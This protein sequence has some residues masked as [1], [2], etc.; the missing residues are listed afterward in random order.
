MTVLASNRTLIA[1]S[2]NGL[3]NRLKVLLSARALAEASGRAMQMRWAVSR[4]CSCD[5]ERLFQNQWNVSSALHLNETRVIDLT[6]MP[7]RAFPDLLMIADAEITVRHYGWLI[8]PT[9]YPHHAPLQKRCAELMDELEPIPN[10]QARVQSLREQFFRDVM[11]GVHLR[12][13]DFVRVRPDT[14]ANLA[15]ATQVVD[16]WLTRQ[17]DA[18]ILVCTDDGAMDPY[19]RQ[20]IRQEGIVENFMK[21]YGERV[22]WTQPRS[23]DRGTPEAIEDA[24]VDLLLL[25]QTNFFVGTRT[26]SFSELAVFGRA[27]PSRFTAAPT[28]AYRRMERVMKW[29]GV[30]YLLTVMNQKEFGEQQSFMTLWY[31]YKSRLGALFPR[32]K[33]KR[34]PLERRAETEP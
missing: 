20:E 14:V 2:H 12:R 5:F 10:I 32:T 1:H 18:G 22:V 13:G 19:A 7:W 27:I 26:S 28:D 9:R 21:R 8:D 15:Q 16:E 23:L 25:R 3:C 24:L 29:T 30:Q 33:R 34:A 31:R 17:P 11:I 4:G 6:K